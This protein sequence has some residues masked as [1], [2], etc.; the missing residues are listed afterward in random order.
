MR[1][2]VRGLEV[3]DLRRDRI[4]APH[5]RLSDH[6]REVVDLFWAGAVLVTVPTDGA[7]EQTQ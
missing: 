6:Y 2:L 4:Y 1:E 3:P 5:R 7:P